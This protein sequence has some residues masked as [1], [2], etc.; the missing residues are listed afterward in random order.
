[1][2]IDRGTANLDMLVTWLANRIN[3]HTKFSIEKE[4]RQGLRTCVTCERFD[5]DNET[6][7]LTEGLRPPAKIIAYG[8]DSY[9]FEFDDIPF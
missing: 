2:N 1:M 5:K 3:V 4:V 6:C 7:K 9:A 8:C